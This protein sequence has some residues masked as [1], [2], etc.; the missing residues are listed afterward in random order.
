MADA[1]VDAIVARLKQEAANAAK[2]LILEIDANLRKATPVDTGHARASWVPSVGTPSSA[3]PSGRSDSEHEAGIG[4]VLRFRLEDNELYETNNAPYINQ[5]NLGNSKQAP[6]GFVEAAIDQ[7]QQT[8][9]QRYDGLQIDVTSTGGGTFSD[10]A[11]GEAAANLAEAY[12][13]FGGEE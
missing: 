13:P 6:A 3:E 4:A 7:A 2:A 12:S 9:Q 1:E 5:L 10:Q 11:G 8:I